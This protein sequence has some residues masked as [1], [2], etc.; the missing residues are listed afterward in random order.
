M[1]RAPVA[2]ELPPIASKLDARRH[3]LGHLGRLGE[4]ASLDAAIER[5]RD[6]ATLS[7]E[8]GNHDEA[9]GFARE[10]LD[11]A[12]TGLLVEQVR[13]NEASERDARRRLDH[14][15]RFA[16][17]LGDEILD[18]RLVVEAG[19]FL[20]A[21]GQRRAALRRALRLGREADLAWGYENLWDAFE[22][23]AASQV[24]LQRLRW[25]AHPGA[26]LP[27]E[28]SRLSPETLA[29]R[30]AEGIDM[31]RGEVDRAARENRERDLERW[32]DALLEADP[33]EAHAQ[34]IR[35]VLDAL[36][37]G[38]LTSDPEL[39]PDLAPSG[40]GDP[41]GSAARMLVRQHAEPNS[42]ALLL[43]RAATMLDAG[44]FGDA[45]ELLVALDQLGPT[46]HER[47]RAL[48]A[49]LAAEVGL[50]SATRAGQ[51]HF[52]SWSKPRSQRRS[53]SVQDFA[54]LQ[55][56]EQAPPLA[57]AIGGAAG[58]ALLGLRHGR[59]A[60]Y[61]DTAMVESLA[62]REDV[63]ERTRERAH[64]VVAAS[65]PSA[66]ARIA[67]CRERELFD[68]DCADLIDELDKLDQSN[69]D[70]QAGLDALG[71]SANTRGEWFSSALWLDAE[72]LRATRDRLAQYEGTRVALTTEFQTAAIF[73]ELAANRPD[74]ARERLRLHGPLLRP[75]T[76]A[77]VAMALADLDE[78]LVQPQ[79]L[80]DLLLEL[81]PVD[82]D[83][84][85]MHERWLPG[86]PGMVEQLFPGRSR[87]AHFA[88]GLALAR[89]GAWRTASAELLLAL[90]QI[91]GAGRAVVA[92]RLAIAA[93][94]AGED[95]LRDQAL[96]VLGVEQPDSFALAYVRGLAAEQI[97]QTALAHQHYLDALIRRPRAVV[98]L[99][100]LLRTL[101]L[102]RQRVEPLRETL[103][104]FPDAGVHWQSAELLELADELDGPTLVRLWLARDA[105]DEALAIGA[106]AARWRTTGE[107]GLTRLTDLLQQATTPDEAFPLAARTLA[108]L[109][110]MPADERVLRR[111]LELW[112]TFLV[113]RT[114]ELEALA[115]ARPLDKG[116]RRP[117][118]STHP[119]LLLA[120]AR[121]A[122]AIDDLTAWAMVR[123][124]AWGSDHA[125]VVAEVAALLAST[126]ADPALAEYACMRLMAEDQR[127]LAA[128]RCVPIWQQRGGSSFLAVDF[129]YVAL[130]QPEALRQAGLEP[131]AVFEFGAQDPALQ[132]DPIWL[133][134]HSLWLSSQGEHEQAATL[135]TRQLALTGEVGTA[136]DDLEFGQAQYRGPL[137]R[138]QLVDEFAPG[139]RRRWALAG[140][141][142]L[143][144]LDLE[145][146]TLYAGRLA[147]WL[148]PID[149][150]APELTA[151]APQELAAERL[152]GEISDAELRSM[153]VYVGH[154]SMM[155]RDDLETGRIDR[156]LM[157][158]L[159]EA[160][161]EDLGL[162]A[163]ES[164]LRRAPDSTFAKLLVL[165]G[166]REARVR[167]RAVELARELVALAPTNPLILNEA[168]PVLTGSEDIEL[169]RRLVA[170]ARALHPGHPWLIDEALPS[171]L[172]SDAGRIPDWLRDPESFDRALAKIDDATIDA[173]QPTRR[174]HTQIAAEAFFPAAAQPSPGSELGVREPIPTPRPSTA[175][176]DAGQP[177]QADRVLF[178]VREPRASRC[179]GLGCADSLIGEWTSRDYALL[180]ARELE[181]PAGPAVEFVVTDGESM[182]DNVLIPT[183]G[184]LFVIIAGSSPEDYAAFLPTIKLARESFRPLDFQ[185]DAFSAETLRTAGSAPPDDRVRFGARR[186]LARVEAG[187]TSCPIDA[188]LR[189][190][191]PATRGELLLDLL[192]TTRG[193]EQRR[194]LLACTTPEA[195]EAARLAL[196]SVLDADAGIHAFGRAALAAHGE[197]V[198]QDT[199]RILF[200]RPE[201]ATSDPGL[202]AD[203]DRPPFGVLQVLALLPAERAQALTREMLGRSDPRLRALALA[204][205]ATVDYFPQGSEVAASEAAA[206][207]EATR[208][209]EVV[210]KGNASEAVLASASL[211]D[212]PGSQSLAVLRTRADA[213]IE[214]KPSDA[215]TRSLAIDL[216]W[217]IA[218][219]LEAGDAKRLRKLA[220]AIVLAPADAR[221][222]A[223]E[224]TR[225]A[226]LE[227]ADDHAAARKALQSATIATNDET[228]SRWAR[229]RRTP[230][231]PRSR[232][233]LATTPLAELL[234]G[235][236]WTYVQVGNAGLFAASLD[237]LLRR[238][239]PGNAADAYLV[240][241]LISDVLL[242][243]F[244]LLGEQGG[245][246]L[247][248]G[249]ECASP[250]GS[251]GF[252]CSAK[253]RDREL[254]LGE[255]AK[256]GLGDDAGLTIPLALV[257]QFAALPLTLGAAPV[258][259]HGFIDVPTEELEAGRSPELARERLRAPRVIAGHPLEYYATIELRED[260]IVVDSEHYMFLDDRLLVFSGAHLAELVL[261]ELPKGS[262]S[263][264]AAPAFQ[265]ARGRWR[266]G[267]AL[268]AVDLA[269]TFGLDEVALELV[270][271]GE[272]LE[273]SA[274]TREAGSAGSTAGST[275]ARELGE[276]GPL[277]ALL[278]GDPATRLASVL[279]P[280][281][282]GERF[283]ELDLARC[284]GTPTE[285]EPCGLRADEALPP[286]ELVEVA[287]AVAL[288]WYA[289]P[290]RDL[291]LWQD[292]VLVVPF[293]AAVRKAALAAKLPTI[294][295]GTIVAHERR[296]WLIRDGALIVASTAALA[297]RALALASPTPLAPDQPRPFVSA[298]MHGQRAAKLVRALAD[299]YEGERRGELLRV[300]AT[301]LGLIGEV[302]LEGSW[303][304]S[305]RGTLRAKLG[306]NL[307]KSE[308][309]LALIDRW[310]ADPE[311]ANAVG[312]PRH[313]ASTDT[314]RPLELLVRVDDAE[315]FA[316][317]SLPDNPRIRVEIAGD[318]R[319][320]VTIQPSAR[321]AGDRAD[322]ALGKDE[323]SRALRHDDQI[324]SDAPAIR[325]V[326]EAL[327]VEGDPSATVAAVVAWV[328]ARIRYEITPT[329]LDAVAVLDRG[330]GDCTEY[331]L[332]TVTLLRAAGIPAELREGMSM[333]G[334]E[335]VAHAWA[336]WHDGNRWHE[337]D[338]TAGTTGVG[339]GHLEIEVVD[340]LALISLGRF[341]ILEITP[342][343]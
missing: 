177:I 215:S 309:E 27:R 149:E 116:L 256:R 32:V 171:V 105:G 337:I 248:A 308:E 125:D 323:R 240:R 46:P 298:S 106:P 338:P 222:K 51:G 41:L 295:P 340:V 76:A 138:Q 92:G 15:A 59:T 186:A 253:V 40:G 6:A 152:E 304:A 286:A 335:M 17:D 64:A 55:D 123:D 231:K 189:E 31:L 182:V 63:R 114:E 77:V 99:D 115:W 93:Q 227:M 14:A 264:A 44:T 81:P 202:T 208:L 145:A 118:E 136:L 45:G 144:G 276:L 255:L 333:G 257:T 49:Q 85:W 87:L 180:W 261:R 96:G 199:Q 211:L 124:Q 187:A 47:E 241:S 235:H 293:D 225:D 273:F 239:A 65:D 312:L 12:R 242:Q 117:A 301:V 147:A 266:E 69:E 102:E 299:R 212:L 35:V 142:A 287:P 141:M 43:A 30:G 252:V 327:I 328:H 334:D 246:D 91:G 5:S 238:L 196:P 157:H 192:L 165:S 313:L 150:E 205:S 285:P 306:L 120:K 28:A 331:A 119:A 314:E 318:D 71:R 137:L 332:L 288:G 20:R 82:V 170:D 269:D 53:A 103:A 169:A 274:H 21:P 204:A 336:A 190:L 88:R 284:T 94:L 128:E 296:W 50:E 341:E 161:S 223:A 181:L 207:T 343:P 316:R 121:D 34:A 291:G 317:T 203:V 160:Y 95:K 310:L 247:A 258:M 89:M 224:R 38:E 214:A 26:G 245:L 101:P 326:A 100:G 178:V 213:V 172:T 122:R 210:G 262:V 330:K 67:L 58:E 2:T 237:D 197:R 249:I 52:A 272:G 283:E 300:L 168:L 155:V 61:L 297:E 36:A 126:P 321:L 148:P 127:E 188:T 233:V 185:F 289:E 78:G 19:Q 140:A 265:A 315:A 183:G 342:L 319:L 217:A 83:A 279:D 166:L 74:L 25:R 42:R 259:L 322:Q 226:I 216:A 70:Y 159:M 56:D 84:A 129:A 234:P 164:V 236:E 179:E 24:A 209:R 107:A 57:A 97:G 281:D 8:L 130:N 13:G 325:E 66:G 135:R 60:P 156:P 250:R 243:G 158:E 260:S 10:Q 221:P 290:R 206:R 267:M 292:W 173:L 98:A 232:A 193:A 162:A 228:P 278:P 18:A 33:H 307:A 134:N 139:D 191:S 263:L 16:V 73:A 23:D 104:L 201:P 294:P 163:Y 143:R 3:A 133:F 151:R 108:W 22:R 112:L 275:G 37:R 303:D 280:E 194:T 268:Q 54:S 154:A 110:A 29:R 254:L 113:G 176:P 339:S 39:L 200:G 230:A 1:G 48:H 7:L 153:A 320:R 11:L 62:I 220:D 174:F 79:Q 218:Q 229:A 72:Q 175:E 111:E 282:I 9:S 131:D 68:N 271:D 270:F 324:R 277:A 251:E 198:V 132:G 90:E 219:R 184:N 244:T 329:S 311:V 109:A 75:E 86:D 167:E 302:E 80:G 146:A 305:G 4:G 195:P